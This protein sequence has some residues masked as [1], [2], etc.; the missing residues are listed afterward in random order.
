MKKNVSLVLSGGGARGI[1]HIGVIEELEKQGYNIHSITG[2][3]MGAVVGGVYAAG[4]LK[5]YKSWITSLDKM[6]VFKLLDFTVGK[7]GFLKGNKVFEALKEF[8]PDLRIEDMEINYS[9]TATDLTNKKE[10]LF[11]KGSLYDAMRA[12]VAIPNVLTPVKYKGSILVDGGVV[13]NIPINCAK[14]IKNDILI[15]VD[16]NANVPLIKVKDKHDNS[17]DK[18][19]SY[20]QKALRKIQKQLN[21]DISSTDEVSLSSFDIM[22][23][24]YEMMSDKIVAM[25]LDVNPPDI[26]IEI[27]GE[28]CS[29]YDF[30]E[31]ERLIRIGQKA[32]VKSVNG[33]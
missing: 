26:L 3:S 18:D 4:K 31:A 11:T 22:S 16:V 28:S 21:M 14:R 13:N 8:I 10:V 7:Q 6:D 2:T 19:S 17:K 29:I 5:E 30:Y 25:A 33:S 1:A 20:Y 15:A 32:T 27:S 9:A 23:K 12:S 24:S